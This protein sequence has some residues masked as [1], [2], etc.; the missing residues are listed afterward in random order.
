MKFRPLHNNILVSR[1]KAEEK[2]PSGLI[3]PDSAKEKQNIAEVLAVGSG[4]TDIKVGDLAYLGKYSGVDVELEGAN[5]V[6]IKADDVLGVL[7]K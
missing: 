5:F 3:I 2:T 4:V 1:Q 7:N 6:I